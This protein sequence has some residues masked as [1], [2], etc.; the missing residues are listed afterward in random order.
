MNQSV[1]RGNPEKNGLVHETSKLATGA[2]KTLNKKYVS[3]NASAFC[4]CDC[5]LSYSRSC[6]LDSATHS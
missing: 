1:S 3:L 2:G 6:V 5:P 4:L